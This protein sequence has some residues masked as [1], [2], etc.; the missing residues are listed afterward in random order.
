MP[1]RHARNSSDYVGGCACPTGNFYAEIRTGDRLIGLGTFD[2]AHEYAHA[3]NAAA[4]PLGRPWRLMNFH[5]VYTAEE[6]QEVAPPPH[7]ITEEE[8]RHHRTQQRRLLIAEE[9]EHRHVMWAERFLEDVLAERAFYTDAAQRAED[10]RQSHRERRLD[11][12]QRRAFIL[13]QVENPTIPPDD[14]R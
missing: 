3:Y 2:T 9:D 11:K 5:D 8:R 6:A 7:L 12:A 4:W 14:P 13:A 10:R 1:L